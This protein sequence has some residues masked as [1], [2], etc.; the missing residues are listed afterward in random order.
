MDSKDAWDVLTTANGQPL[1]E[2]DDLPSDELVESCE[3]WF[4]KHKQEIDPE[5]AK[6]MLIRELD[7]DKEAIEEI[8]S[9]WGAI[10]KYHIDILEVTVDM[11]SAW[12]RQKIFTLKNGDLLVSDG[13]DG[14]WYPEP[15]S[16][17]ILPYMASADMP[18]V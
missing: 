2:Y 17:F 16:F 10:L 14:S 15:P 3:R 11:P 4:A 9:D 5:K 6:E 18:E 8:G 7:I 1:T 12:I 13:Y